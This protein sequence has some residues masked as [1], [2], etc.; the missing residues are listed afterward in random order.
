MNRE[1]TEANYRQIRDFLKRMEQAYYKGNFIEYKDFKP[2]TYRGVNLVKTNKTFNR[3]G[4]GFSGFLNRIMGIPSGTVTED[5]YG[6]VNQGKVT[7]FV[8]NQKALSKYVDINGILYT[9]F[10]FIFT[11]KINYSETQILKVKVNHQKEVDKIYQIIDNY[12]FK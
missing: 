2:V 1:V 9:P 10:A 4:S 6:V 11:L 12:S 8:N 5:G 3:Y 7:Y